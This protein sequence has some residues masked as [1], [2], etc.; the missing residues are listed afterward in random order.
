MITVERIG[1]KMSNNGFNS[2]KCNPKYA[3]FLFYKYASPAR[4]KRKNLTKVNR[5]D[6]PGGLFR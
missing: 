2:L 4:S 5:V 3:D 6:I 1:K